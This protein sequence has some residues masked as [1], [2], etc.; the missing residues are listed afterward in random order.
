MIASLHVAF[1]GR[2]ENRSDKNSVPSERSGIT[3][4]MKLVKDHSDRI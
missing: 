3:S 1:E 2:P 4:H